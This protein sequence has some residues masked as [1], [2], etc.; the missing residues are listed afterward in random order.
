MCI[1]DSPST[2]HES[3]NIQSSPAQHVT[4]DSGQAPAPSPGG[5][6]NG[7]PRT[8]MPSMGPHENIYSEIETLERSAN[9]AGLEQIQYFNISINLLRL[10]KGTRPKNSSGFP[11]KEVFNSVIRSA[12]NFSSFF[13][14][15]LWMK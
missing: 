10:K 4:V 8:T 15:N 9:K 1:R 3:G 13:E 6:R 14:K 2:A 7:V 11:G 5:N 12:F